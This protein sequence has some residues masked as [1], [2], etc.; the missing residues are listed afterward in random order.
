MTGQSFLI[1]N[2]CSCYEKSL[3]CEQPKPQK[4][5]KMKKTTGI[6]ISFILFTALLP[7]SGYTWPI[8]DSGQTKC[9]DD[10]GNE[11]NPC[12]SPG[13]DFYGQDGNYLINPPSYTK[14]DSAGN[15]LPDAATSWVMVRDNVTGLIWE[16]KQ[17]KDSVKNYADPHDADNTY[18]WY[19][20][21]PETNSGYAGTPGD[22]TDTEDFITQL[23]SANFG[24]YSDWRLP[25]IKEL[26]SLANLGR[27]SPA[28]DISYFPNTISSYY[29]SSTTYVDS[30]YCAWFMNFSYGCDIYSY[31]I[32]KF[33]RCYVRAVRNG[34]VRSFDNLIINN[35]GTVTDTRTGLMWQKTTGGTITWKE[36]LS[37]C[38]SL[39]LA[40]Y[41]D[42]RL[43]I[44]EELRSLADYERYNPAI[45]TSVFPD[46]VS[47]FYWSSTN[48]E[49]D[50]N[51]YHGNGC[52]DYTL[53][54][55]DVRDVRAVRGGQVRL[56]GHLIISS[57]AQASF[58]DS[59]VIMPIT[60]QTQSIS[61]NVKITLSRDGGKTF[62][63]IADST[64]NDG[65]YNWTVSGNY[66]VNCVLKIE[67]LNDVAKGTS[68][69]LF[70]IVSPLT[71]TTNSVSSITQTTVASGGNVISDGGSSV[72]TRGV[73]WSTSQN[74]T[75]SNSKTT[76]GTGTGSFTSSLTG[77][78]ANTTYYVRA[79]ATNSAGTA[80]GNELS[81]TT[82]ASTRIINLNGSLIFGNVN[83]SSGKQ[84]TFTISN[85]GNSTLTVSSISYPAGFTGNWSGTIPASGSRTVT[86]TFTPT[87]AQSY[88][89][90]VTVN[91][92]KTGGTNT[93]S[94]SG[95]GTSVTRIIGLSG[96]LAFGNVNVN[97]TKQLSFT[98]SNSGNS[99]LT[100]SSIAYPSGF[101]GNWS[102]G[103]IA[104]GGSQ[105]VT[106]TFKPT[107]AI[108]Y[109]GT[110][111]V[112]SDKTSGTNTIAA[113]GT[114]ISPLSYT[115]SGY[116]KDAGNTGI[117]S[118]TLTFSNNGGTAVTDGSGFYSK[119]VSSGWTG[120]VTPSKTGISF[121][122][123]TR[124]Y[125]NVTANSNDQNYTGGTP[126]TVFRI[127]IDKN[128]NGGY[129]SGEGIKDASVRVNSETADRGVTDDQGIISLPNIGN[130]AK[131][132]AQKTLY[133]MSNPKAGDANFANSR[134]QNPYYA[135]SVNG[136][137]YDFVMASD[138]MGADGNY[139]DFPGAGKTLLNASKDAQGNILVQL[140]HPKI[141]WNLVVAF[142]EAQSTAFYDQIKSG[143]RS[144][145]DYM[146]NYTDGYSVVRNVIF[147]KGAYL[148][149]A[150]WNYSDVQVFN[151][152]G[153]NATM[154]GN[155]YNH[156]QAHLRMGKIWWGD[157]PDEYDWY[158]TLGHE[159][160]HYLLGFGD[161]YVNGD[162]TKGSNRNPLWPYRTS[163]DGDPG[164]PNE[165]PKN[166]GI[167]NNEHSTHEMSDPTEYFPRIYSSSMDPDLV[168]H[169]FARWF[170]PS[171]PSEWKGKSCWSFFK[172][173]YQ[174]DIKQQMAASG[175]T[176]FSDAFFNN[177]I[178]PPH[179]TGS[180]PGSDRTKRS[181]PALMNHDSVTFTDF[182]GTGR[183]ASRS[184]EV[185][186][187]LALVLDET[188]T[189]VS[190]AD[191]W[192]VSPDRRSFQGKSD[193]N[194][195]VKC[196]S[197]LIGKY[198]EA[199][200]S[201]RKAEIMIDAVQD[202]YV[203]ILPVF[204]SARADES[205]GMVITAKPDSTNPKLL[206]VTASGMSLTSA[207]AVTL[208]QSHGYSVNIA[209]T[210][211]GT[212][213]YSG[214]ADCQY[215]SGILEVTSGAIPW[216]N[217]F[218]IF[219]TE[220]GPASGYYAPN[221]ELEMT[222]SPNTFTGTGSFVIVNSSSPAPP[223]FGMIQVGNVYSFGFSDTVTA[224]QNVTLNITLPESGKGANLNL[225]GW[226][227]DNKTWNPVPGGISG[228]KYFSIAIASLKDYAA[229]AMFA[230]PQA[231]D[232]N[233][234]AP[235]TGF[236]ASTGTALWNV[237]L[238]WTA[239]NDGDLSAYDIRF[240][241]VPV[242]ESNWNNC[243]T[244]GNIPEPV[245]GTVQTFTAEMPD[246]GVLY[247]FG[248]KVI[249]GAGNLSPLTVLSSPVKSNAP[250][251]D[252]DGLPDA[253][254]DSN[255]SNLNA[256]TDDD[257]DLLSNLQ[258][259][260][261]QTDP[262]HSDTDRDGYS[263][264]DEI[265]QGTDPL[266]AQSSPESSATLLDVIIG[267]QILAG[268]DT[269]P[270]E[271][272]DADK[273]GKTELKDVLINL[274]SVADVK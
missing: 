211:S 89:G 158:S 100:V 105:S 53:F 247:Y 173:F 249:D 108:S 78:T 208:S 253:W 64:P 179:I 239:P 56:L 131:I 63:T 248:I 95:T 168:T 217:P 236:T 151:Q 272:A 143:F 44:R 205:A 148:D 5:K 2:P 55:P 27:Y 10:A 115:I 273:D 209:M 80:Y 199:Y 164:E 136:K 40:G 20:S 206:T 257:G 182:S 246:P 118:V 185:F 120:L 237:N 224:V 193:G 117:G 76:D 79:Y 37:Y 203:L 122:P 215:D 181:G 6:F 260:Q 74:P 228:Q 145:A 155:R 59:G 111:T 68:Q 194:G 19:D 167:M 13:Q 149:S 233:P 82:L 198:L 216:L 72:T 232:P 234:P 114:G 121:T 135:G 266:D 58:W 204:R 32:C 241:T 220:V 184:E 177:L 212:N 36:S 66:S 142:E 110:V 150:Q 48:C 213:Q 92:D 65:S 47:S 18:T 187:A 146:Y 265:W 192:L 49:L 132:Y 214:T 87:A 123:A 231:N 12:P 195:T 99:A 109:G 8:P 71:V 97:S 61:G 15:S 156:Y 93:L 262:K 261:Y 26:A 152:M 268:I 86:V 139:S 245:P 128:G 244:A 225:Y 23:N 223:N 174:N 67:P 165:F 183:A 25:T 218:E 201:G 46:A 30:T 116:V 52:D 77:L 219:S 91:S 11:L 31:D 153:P 51:F 4:E 125:S 60:W 50:L 138:I 28:A 227:I 90:T 33:Y 140:V 69:G 256:Q 7:L 94:I 24:G 202:T 57:P 54:K 263:D 130:D 190:D 258:E 238:Q 119:T 88:S 133:A 103:T 106:V 35:D 96:S 45:D 243:I 22:G 240:S 175:L 176:G 162:Y 85:T 113:S 186:D 43:P 250:D 267:L 129:D 29:W 62:E 141:G 137:M 39:T 242:S 126:P 221:G 197:L 104:A 254:E 161:E 107:A 180:Y 14:L 17:N 252:K 178:V 124:S 229:Y 171:E 21:N 73:C 270:T 83:V 9:Y 157:N 16:V 38:E 34:Q 166:Y 112:N 41:S 207:P 269:N 163:H 172:M 101:T 200:Y 159:S 222:Y 75:T 144:Y 134:T 170:D 196:G 264:G 169:Q 226:D 3:Q 154:F 210:A 160:G 98:V 70:V 271:S 191:V 81:F 230:L 251:S 189:P 147:V 84:L 274:R 1:K 188:G 42:W 235:V 127:W 259:Y 102:S 255:G